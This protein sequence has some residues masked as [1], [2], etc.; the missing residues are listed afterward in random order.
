MFIDITVKD[1]RNQL[2]LQSCKKSFNLKQS[3]KSLSEKAKFASLSRG[4]LG[5]PSSHYSKV[6]N[7]FSSQFRYMLCTE[8]IN[9]L[10]KHW[11]DPRQTILIG[12]HSLFFAVSI[13]STGQ[14]VV[15]LCR[16]KWLL[17]PKSVLDLRVARGHRIPRV[18]R[19]VGINDY[20]SQYPLLTFI[21]SPTQQG[22]VEKMILYQ[23]KQAIQQNV[24][25]TP[26]RKS[27]L[28]LK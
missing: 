14:F 17:N 16:N 21:Q 10:R 7:L 12:Y 9:H 13:N 18:T 24:R 2:Y 11:N 5:C 3:L 26:G 25:E 15:Y 22:V 6:L 8:L 20:S 28:G 23:L 27:L 4:Y 19:R 1:L